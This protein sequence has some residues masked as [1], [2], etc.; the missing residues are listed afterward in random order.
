MFFD[1]PKSSDHAPARSEAQMQALYRKLHVLVHATPMLRDFAEPLA[2]TLI[3]V[4]GA[5]GIVIGRTHGYGI[6]LITALGCLS[7]M[8]GSLVE[9]DPVSARPLITS[10]KAYTFSHE[11]LSAKYPIDDITLGVQFD[12]I[13]LAPMAL[14]G[15][16]YG[17]VGLVSLKPNFYSTDD[18]N[19]LREITRFVSMML[20]NIHNHVNQSELTHY[21]RIAYFASPAVAQLQASEI[22]MLQTL[23]KLRE[24]YITG[25]YQAMVDPLSQAFAR[26]ESIAK[27]TQDLR[28]I[29]DLGKDPNI[30]PAS[31][32]VK[33]LLEK[34]I[35][36]D[37]TKL[38]EKNIDVILDIEPD[39]PNIEADFSI[40][41]QAI[42]EIVLNAMDALDT[43][44]E[45]S[46]KEL[47]LRAYAAPNLVQ[48]EIS[49]NA[50]GIPAADYPRIFE[51][52]FTTR[53]NHKGLGLTRA[54]LNI[55]RSNGEI[56]IVPRDQGGTC[57]H[58]LFCDEEHTP[59]KNV[60]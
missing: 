7:H 29:S 17:F 25:N 1:P 44:Q 5:D 57:V 34:A 10:D 33:E 45:G 32:N 12:T 24:Y 31:I 59:Q 23:A 58:I 14:E 37:G 6:Q 53:K 48:I 13:V 55:L 30:L 20:A 35:E 50:D 51:P 46:L 22:D 43:K 56:V 8:A 36:Y 27:R 41:W 39:I 2:T 3:N 49:D 11:S 52:S 19:A 47:T 28:A 16:P 4:F 26:I 42:H 40:M 38:D 9:I 60:F 54:K 18:V 21:E 15:R